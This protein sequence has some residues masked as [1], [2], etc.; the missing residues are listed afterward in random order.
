MVRRRR[1]SA[2]APRGRG[3]C[4]RGRSAPGEMGAGE[5]P[6][7]ARVAA[8]AAARECLRAVTRT[9]AAYRRRGVTKLAFATGVLH[10]VVTTFVLAAAPE[11]S[12]SAHARRG[13]TCKSR[14]REC[15][16]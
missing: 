10:L 11:V 2:R 13:C 12:A 6:A 8:A 4:G 1:H 7:G 9:A 16:I 15:P 14:A 3:P 5:D